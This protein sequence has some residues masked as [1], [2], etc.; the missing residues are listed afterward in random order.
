MDRGLIGAQGKALALVAAMLERGGVVTAQEF[1][2]LLGIFA[3]T[4]AQDDADEGDIL[5]VW[6]A[7]VK[8]S[9]DQSKYAPS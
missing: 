8:E 5:C 6:A 3:V 2:D 9:A 4:V 7:I 1:G